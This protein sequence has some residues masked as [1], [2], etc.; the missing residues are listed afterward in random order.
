M[1]KISSPWIGYASGKLGEGVY[2]RADGR[3]CARARNRAPH[4]PKTEAQCIQR[5]VLANSARFVSELSEIYDHS[6]FGVKDGTPSM[7]AARSAVMVAMRP[8][9][10]VG[11]GGSAEGG[12]YFS[13]KLSPSVPVM[14]LPVSKGSLAA[15]NF[16]IKGDPN[17]GM[18]ISFEAPAGVDFGDT[19]GDVE[20]LDLMN[21]LGIKFGE[22]LS[23]VRLLIS[24]DNIV[25]TDVIEGHDV[26]NYFVTHDKMANVALD[27]AA[28]YIS[29]FASD[30]P[31]LSTSAF[32][33][34]RFGAYVDGGRDQFDWQARR[35][36]A[37][38]SSP[39]EIQIAVEKNL[40]AGYD[41]AAVAV[42]RSAWK[43]SEVDYSTAKFIL[44][45]TAVDENDS[46]PMFLTYGDVQAQQ[47]G[48]SKNYL[49]HPSRD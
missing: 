15:P 31:F 16:K 35:V 17:A 6:F 38:G 42:I 37:S 5:M 27:S 26:T 48:G 39:A 4:N 34:F 14:P 7:R 21:T 36:A 20:P 13:A 10:L 1:A 3:Q 18:L 28:D 43:G 46:M 12:A 8:F 33:S 11:V 24:F 22:Q 47:V 41:L 44:N 30:D 25:Y 40:P 19:W 9:A 32:S 45:T 23:I 49:D 29:Q 2:Y